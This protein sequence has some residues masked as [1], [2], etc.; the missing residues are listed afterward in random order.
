MTKRIQVT[1]SKRLSEDLET[2]ANYDGRPL[3][4]LTAYLLERAIEDAKKKGAQWSKDN[5]TKHEK[6]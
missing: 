2:W 6:S 5:S 4:N 3:S 1:I